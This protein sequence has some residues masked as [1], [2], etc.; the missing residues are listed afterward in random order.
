MAPKSTIVVST[1]IPRGEHE[2]LLAR[3]KYLYES[4][5]IRNATI[6]SYMKFLIKEDL[7]YDRKQQYQNLMKSLDN[8]NLMRG[9]P[10][11]QSHFPSILPS[12]KSR[13]PFVGIVGA[14]SIP[15]SI[16]PCEQ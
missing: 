15:D 9:L 2:Y 11:F 6:S 12:I 13:N 1:K 16:P 10:G 8:P 3:A 7:D 14:D 4:Q 5:S